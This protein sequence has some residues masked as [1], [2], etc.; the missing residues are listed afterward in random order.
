LTGRIVGPL[1]KGEGV[2]VVS[3]EGFSVEPLA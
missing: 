3:D 2:R 1:G